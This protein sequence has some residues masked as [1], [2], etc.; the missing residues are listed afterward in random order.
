[1]NRV[2]LATVEGMSPIFL[3]FHALNEKSMSRTLDASMILLETA[4]SM[5]P[6][7]APVAVMRL[8]V[9]RAAER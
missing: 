2:C 8:D 4:S 5:G 3:V 9:R 6:Y 1:M 7:G